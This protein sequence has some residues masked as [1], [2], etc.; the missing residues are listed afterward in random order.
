MFHRMIFFPDNRCTRGLAY[1]SYLLSRLKLQILMN[2]LQQDHARMERDVSTCLGRIFVNAHSD[3]WA[4]IVTKVIYLHKPIFH[5][6]TYTYTDIPSA[7]I[8]MHIYEKCMFRS[9]C[10][11]AQCYQHLHRLTEVFN[12]T[13]LL[14]C[15]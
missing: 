5:Q 11:F 6:Q 2:V 10:P 1:P 8:H 9:A 13:M 12:K 14:M 4:R 15:E 7:N 3:G